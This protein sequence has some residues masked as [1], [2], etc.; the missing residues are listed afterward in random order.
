MATND[1]LTDFLTA[2]ADAIRSVKGTTKAINPQDF[3]KWIK[4][5]E[6]RSC[7]EITASSAITVYVDESSVS[8]PAK[9]PTEVYPTTSFGIAKRN[10]IY[11]GMYITAIDCSCLN[12][13][14]FTSMANMFYYCNAPEL[15]VSEFN[16][17]QVTN[18]SYMFYG[19]GYLLSLDVSGWDTS[20]VTN[21]IYMFNRCSSLTSLDL[22]GWD[23]SKVT[24]MEYMFLNCKSLSSIKF[25]P[26]WGKQTSTE[27]NALTLDLSVC[28][29]NNSYQFSDETWSS[30]LT[31]Y[32]RATA[33]LTNMTI[34]LNSS[35]NIPD[36]WIA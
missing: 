23:T 19:C 17:S 8:I 11:Q 1:N 33:G 34:T 30:M 26:G 7:M 16:T 2:V 36:G 13:S 22:S 15:D 4:K 35:T 29:S 21:M 25:G 3:V 14:K 10:G 18:M 27:A 20:K 12:T 6:L 32:D 24:S 5:M 9:T 31:M 28:N